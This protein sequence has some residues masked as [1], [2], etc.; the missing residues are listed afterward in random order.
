MFFWITIN[1][2]L[3]SIRNFNIYL[4][5]VPDKLHH[6][7]LGLYKYQIE[8]TREVLKY[9]CGTHGIKIM[10]ER[11]SKIPRF[12]HLKKFKNG[13]GDISR[14]T[15]DDYWNLMKIMVF[16]IE[17]ILKNKSDKINKL[18]INLYLS[19]NNMYLMSRKNKFSENDLTDFQV[20]FP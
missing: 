19:W 16:V 10:D 15:A 13:L 2:S 3:S 6:L 1:L 12:K 11:I 9:H 8:Y 14:F 18:L 20:C 7:D 17:D 5:T 4:A